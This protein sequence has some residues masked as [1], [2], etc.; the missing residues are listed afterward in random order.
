VVHLF[1]QWIRPHLDSGALEPVLQDWWRPFSGPF[2][3]YPS[4]RY[5]PAPLRAFVQFVHASSQDLFAATIP[6]KCARTRR[7]VRTGF[8]R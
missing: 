3:Y 4:R 7:G 1:E 5:M 8:M 2:L 6:A